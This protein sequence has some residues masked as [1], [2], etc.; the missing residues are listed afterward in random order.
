MKIKDKNKENKTITNAVT[1]AKKETK[2]AELRF[3]A[4]EINK[5]DSHSKTYQ[6]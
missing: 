6:K 3:S 1:S 2:N 4:D 5:T